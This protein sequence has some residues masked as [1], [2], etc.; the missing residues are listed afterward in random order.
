MAF[1]ED[2]LKKIYA[3]TDGYCHICCKKLSFANYAQSEQ[4]GAWEVEHSRP[5]AKGGTDHLNNLYPACI[6]CNRDKGTITSKTAR[7][8]NGRK[9]A[10]LSKTNKRRVKADNAVASGIVGGLIGLVFGPWGSVAGASIGAKLG[11]S[12]DPNK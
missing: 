6:S 3:R 12:V 8:W 10:P 1:D 11:H 5:R 7:A 2:R 9:K 4:K